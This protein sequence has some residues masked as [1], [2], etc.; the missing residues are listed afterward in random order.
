MLDTHSGGTLD[1]AR[2]I[3]VGQRAAWAGFLT[4]QTGAGVLIDKHGAIRVANGLVEIGISSGKVLRRLTSLPPHGL[5][6]GNALDATEN[7]IAVD[8]S[9]SYLLLA[10]IGDGHGA[11]FRWTFGMPHPVRITSGAL[12]ADWAG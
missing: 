10:G 12:V 7:T 4:S 3:E 2:A 5:A 1:R 9:G 11:I 8:R 6:T